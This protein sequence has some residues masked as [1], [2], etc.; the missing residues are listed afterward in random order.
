MLDITF[1]ILNFKYEL[2]LHYITLH[3]EYWISNMN[4][5]M[6]DISFSILNFKYELSNLR[7][8]ILNIESQIWITITLH[9]ITFWILNF[10]YELSND[11]SWAQPPIP[12]LLTRWELASNIKGCNVNGR[13][14][15][16]CYYI[17]YQIS[18]LVRIGQSCEMSRIW[19]IYPCKKIGRLG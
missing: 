8:Y 10:K 1:W 2:P 19:R 17:H 11:K 7:Y 3:F 13:G 18:I 5:Q 16:F 12:M 15:Q 4:Y 6:L 9:Y 14:S